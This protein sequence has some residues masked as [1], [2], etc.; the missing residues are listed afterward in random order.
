MS[1]W[2]EGLA[3]EQL[4]GKH[5]HVKFCNGFGVTDLMLTSPTLITLGPDC[6]H[7]AILERDDTSKAWRLADCVASV[8]LRK[9]P[10]ESGYYRDREGDVWVV[11]EWG[12]AA[13][14]QHRGEPIAD[15]SP[16]DLC[17]ITQYAPFEPVHFEDGPDKIS[18]DGDV[19]EDK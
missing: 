14:V 4:E 9:P 5:V 3:A 8:S 7:R 16:L 1:E 6:D 18:A 13:L 10:T 15:P 19:K 2:Y 11:S 17:E 12:R